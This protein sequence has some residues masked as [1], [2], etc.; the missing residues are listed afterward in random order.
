MKQGQSN[1]MISFH[2]EQNSESTD[3]EK[4]NL[5]KIQYPILVWKWIVSQR[6]IETD[7]G[8]GLIIMSCQVELLN[9]TF[10]KSGNATFLWQRVYFV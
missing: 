4:D 7:N 10:Q 6:R 5:E 9:L 1:Q 2:K 3:L 8:N